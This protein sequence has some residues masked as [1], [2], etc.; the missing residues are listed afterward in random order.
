MPAP[1]DLRGVGDRIE[2]LLARLEACLDQDAWEQV[3]DVV[4]LVTELYGGGLARIL[5]IVDDGTAA[6]AGMRQRMADDDLVASLLV[7]HDLHPLDLEQRVGEALE[8]VRPYLGSHGGDV[9]LV[10]IDG[11]AGVVRLRLLGSCDGC[12]SSSVTLELAVREAIEAAAPEITHIDTT[13]GEAGP[14]GDAPTGDQPLMVPVTLGPKPTPVDAAVRA[15][16]R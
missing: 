1:T 5:E 4:S 15:V 11:E 12:P 16:P 6:S 13:G 2:E 8:S 7:L 14:T 9:E 3:Q 10:S